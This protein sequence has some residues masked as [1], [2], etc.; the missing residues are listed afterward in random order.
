MTAI[1]ILI[2]TCDGL[3]DGEVCPEE[4][5]GD[6]EIRSNATLR[7]WAA[8]EGW[9]AADGRDWCP[10]AHD[11]PAP[12]TPAAGVL[13]PAPTDTTQPTTGGTH[14]HDQ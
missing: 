8:D 4:Y 1:H 5:G 2:L 12:P 6:L 3:L 7:K 13:R 10:S 14:E 9:T 11:W